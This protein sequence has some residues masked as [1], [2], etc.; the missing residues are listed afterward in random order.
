MFSQITGNSPFFVAASG[1]RLKERQAAEEAV[2][3]QTTFL[4]PH[5]MHGCTGFPAA[6]L[7]AVRMGPCVSFLL[8]TCGKQPGSAKAEL[9]TE[10][11]QSPVQLPAAHAQLL[12]DLRDRVSAWRVE[13]LVEITYF[14]GLQAQ[15]KGVQRVFLF[16]SGYVPVTLSQLGFRQLQGPREQFRV[17]FPLFFQQVAALLER[18]GTSSSKIQLS[19]LSAEGRRLQAIRRYRFPSSM[20][21]TFCR[22]PAVRRSW[23]HTPFGLQCRLTASLGLAYP[24]AEATSLAQNQTLP[25]ASTVRTLPNSGCSVMTNVRMSFTVYRLILSL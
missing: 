10:S 3:E 5:R 1:E 22:P 18:A 17:R 23:T 7:P 11:L 6:A 21:F 19:N 25:P 13:H 4:G 9:D 2:D 16:Q 20:N 14:R 12:G 24:N 8:I 15:F